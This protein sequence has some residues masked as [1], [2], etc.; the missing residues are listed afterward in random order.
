ML[1]PPRSRTTPAPTPHPFIILKPQTGWVPAAHFTMPSDAR[2]LSSKLGGCPRPIFTMP[3]D[4]RA[5][6]TQ[7]GRVPAAQFYHARGCTHTTGPNRTG[8][9]GPVLPCPWMHAH[10]SLTLGVCPQPIS[11][12]SADARA[13]KAHARHLQ[14]GRGRF[15]CVLKLTNVRSHSLPS[16]SEGCE[17]LPNV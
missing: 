17:L 9:R 2:A 14:T 16:D 13:P 3:A 15:G 4:A 7:H 11:T 10:Q 8:A 12:I 5:K 1:I 6:N